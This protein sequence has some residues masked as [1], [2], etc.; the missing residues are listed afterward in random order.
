LSAQ[1]IASQ[2]VLDLPRDDVLHVLS[3]FDEE[4]KRLAALMH[5]TAL[6]GDHVAFRRTAHALAGAAGAVGAVVLEQAA[7]SA[8]VPESL[9]AERMLATA[10]DI[11]AL[12]S[13][14]REEAAGV[15]AKLDPVAHKA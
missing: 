10:S 3:V 6:N 1:P 2:W 14:A 12:S 5:Q 11:A 8:M 9:S 4:C 15:A 13:A 7:R